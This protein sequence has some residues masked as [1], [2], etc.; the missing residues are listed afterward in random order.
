MKNT[1]K[2]K[3]VGVIVEQGFVAGLGLG[4]NPVLNKE[5]YPKDKQPAA[6]QKDKNKK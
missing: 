2:N 6:N 5:L 3:N 1:D 4:F